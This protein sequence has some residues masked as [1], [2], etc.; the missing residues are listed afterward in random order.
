MGKTDIRTLYSRFENYGNAE[1][2]MFKIRKYVYNVKIDLCEPGFADI[3]TDRYI[4]GFLETAGA[5][6]LGSLGSFGPFGPS[7]A[8]FTGTFPTDGLNMPSRRREPDYVLTAELENEN[9]DQVREILFN[10]GALTVDE[11]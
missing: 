9:I 4:P 5:A 1:D 11:S 8:G 6:G 10:C 7:G 3:Y 2:A